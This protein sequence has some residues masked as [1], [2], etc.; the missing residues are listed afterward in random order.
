V[1]LKLILNKRKTSTGDACRILRI[2]I[3]QF[4]VVKNHKQNGT[5]ISNMF[6]ALE[7]LNTDVDINRACETITEKIKISAK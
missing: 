2:Y 1:H 5:E 7:N 4:P 3:V 6:A